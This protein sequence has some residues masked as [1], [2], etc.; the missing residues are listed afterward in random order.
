MTFASTIP[1]ETPI[2]DFCHAVHRRGRKRPI[3][4]DGETAREHFRRVV[5]EVEGLFQLLECGCNSALNSQFTLAIS[6]E[7]AE[8]ENG[9]I[10]LENICN[11]LIEMGG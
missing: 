4:K 5:D 10:A 6:L 11:N 9:A 3:P 1:D 8:P 7:A 2:M